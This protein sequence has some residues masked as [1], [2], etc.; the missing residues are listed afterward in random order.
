MK[1]TSKYLI[2]LLLVF[3]LSQVFIYSE[4][5]NALI[6]SV[7]TLIFCWVI[8][9]LF[10]TKNKRYLFKV[11]IPIILGYTWA[12]ITSLILKDF[13]LTTGMFGGITLGVI[14]SLVYHLV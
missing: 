11:F 1:K 7:Y 12:L 9:Y 10:N 6:I 2:L 3:L 13:Y 4:F 8:Y 5:W 14:I